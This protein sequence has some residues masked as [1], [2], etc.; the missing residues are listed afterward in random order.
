MLTTILL[1]L[2]N[3]AEEHVTFA[4]H[5]FLR[6]SVALFR[7]IRLA[8]QPL[9]SSTFL[10]EQISNQQPTNNTFSLKTN[11]H[12]PPTINQTSKL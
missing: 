12:Q 5:Y 3:H 9:T 8:Y 6:R 7:P 4:I 1:N 2:W 10:S 11:Q